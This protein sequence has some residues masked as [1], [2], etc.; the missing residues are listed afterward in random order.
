MADLLGIQRL[1]EGNSF[2]VVCPFCGD[3]RG[4]MNFRIMKGNMPANTYHCFCCGEK[5]NMLTLYADMKGIY[6]E[7]RYKIAYREILEALKSGTGSITQQECFSV[8]GTAKEEELADLEVRDRVYRR[9]L[10][11][12]SLSGNH[13]KNL[14]ER[15]LTDRQIEEGWFRSTPVSGTENLARKLVAEGYPLAGIPGFFFNARKNWDAAFYRGNR[16]FLCPAYSLDGKIAGFQIRLDEPVD[17]RKYLWFSSANKNRGTGSKSPVTFL[18]DPCSR[19]VRVTEGILKPMIAHSL[20]GFSFLG[21]PGVN[22]YK[23]LAKALALLKQNGLEEVQ[24]YYDM[25]KH[26]DIRCHGDYKAAECADCGN[27]EA[28]KDCGICGKKQKK[29]DQIREGC[30][31]LY[32]ICE[33]LSLRCVRKQWDMDND[34]IWTGRYKGIDDYWQAYKQIAF[35]KEDRMSDAFY[36]ETFDGSSLPPYKRS[37]F[38]G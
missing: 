3:K 38:N 34:G 26:L 25:D 4:K 28:G 29:R 19:T 37:G 30:C 21:T 14:R 10:E 13:R 23:E 22:Q 15:G 35:L 11:L 2:G 32:E 20:S 33:D 18:G 36:R 7:N 5:G 16:G 12:L 27:R 9:L 8:T 17:G 1:S 6:G 31:R 24:E